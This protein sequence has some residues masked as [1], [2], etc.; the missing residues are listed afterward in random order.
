MNGHV[1]HENSAILTEACR[2]H[3]DDPS[4]LSLQGELISRY[5]SAAACGSTRSPMAAVRYKPVVFQEIGLITFR[6][7]PSSVEARAM[8]WSCRT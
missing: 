4:I 3:E 1:A 2:R 8:E 5:S 7:V 6:E